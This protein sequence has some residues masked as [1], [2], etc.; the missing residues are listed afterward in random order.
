[1]ATANTML[2]SAYHEP[3]AA[4]VTA[5]SSRAGMQPRGHMSG[6]PSSRS[7][8]YTPPQLN[9]RQSMSAS[10]S[11]KNGSQRGSTSVNRRAL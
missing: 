10:G 7:S 6:S 5:G 9:S 11:L 2:W 4:S 8:M 1:M 3:P